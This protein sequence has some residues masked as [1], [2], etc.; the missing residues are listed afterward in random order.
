MPSLMEKLKDLSANYSEL[1]VEEQAYTMQVKEFLAT[2]FT[3]VSLKFV[4][5]TFH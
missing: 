3:A 5:I 2:Y 1:K 4:E